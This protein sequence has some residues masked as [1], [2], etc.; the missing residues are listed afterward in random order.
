MLVKEVGEEISLALCVDGNALFLARNTWNGER[1][2]LFRVRDPE[3]ANVTL[4]RLTTG[5]D[6]KRHLEYRMWSDPE[7]SEAQWF[8]TAQTS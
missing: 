2:L 8:F 1:Q 7:W 5:G 6:E 4:Q 3:T